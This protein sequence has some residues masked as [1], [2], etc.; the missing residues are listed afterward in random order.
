MN[1]IQLMIDEHVY[2][3]RMLKVMRQ[4]CLHIFNHEPVD[5]ADFEL[6]IE[7][8][9]EYADKHHHGKE[10]E[11]LFNRILAE[12]GELG[13]KLINYGMLVEHTQGRFFIH[14][15]ELAIQR[16]KDGDQEAQLDLIANAIS[17]TNLLDRHIDKEDH[18]VYT[19][20]QR[21]LK[22]D[23]IE[24]IDSECQDFEDKQ[25]KLKIQ[26]KYINLVESLELKYL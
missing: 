10:E 14:E 3:K 6:M 1:V 11:L 13:D 15:L 21:M 19:F 18:V 7:F 24:L 17:Y 9:K 2:I 8:V 22:P 25:T 16:I 20:A 5:Y 12:T 26:E 4:A 23:T